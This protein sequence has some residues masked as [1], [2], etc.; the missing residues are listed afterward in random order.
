MCRKV[1]QS[2]HTSLLSTHGRRQTCEPGLPSTKPVSCV[3]QP[4]IS[5][6]RLIIGC[7]R[8]GSAGTEFGRGTARGQA[9]ARR[10]GEAP[11][12]AR[13][14][15][16]SHALCACVRGGAIEWHAPR[17]CRRPRQDDQ[18]PGD[19]YTT[20]PFRLR[21]QSFCARARSTPGARDPPP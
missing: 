7:D 19:S 6:A 9:L 8:G 10:R 1:G 18:G 13:R 14:A 20:G 5:L 4:T 16:A 15:T 12:G 17:G 11:R 3:S 2:L 21:T